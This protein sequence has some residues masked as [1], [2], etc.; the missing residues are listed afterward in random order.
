MHKNQTGD[1]L[2]VV[3]QFLTVLDMV[4]G[5][6]LVCREWYI[7][8]KSE[9]AWEG[10]REGIRRVA[11]GVVEHPLKGVRL[12][13]PGREFT[14]YM[15]EH[16]G[17]EMC[18]EWGDLE[19]EWESQC[20]WVLRD[21]VRLRVADFQVNA[22]LMLEITAQHIETELAYIYSHTKLPLQ[23]H[24]STPWQSLA[25]AL[26]LLIH[27]PSSPDFINPVEACLTTDAYPLC[28]ALIT[29][30]VLQTMCVT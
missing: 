24:I 17:C 4:K 12:A 5:M 23:A 3:A 9:G 20:L 8:S 7:T 30:K 28:D 27:G 2:Q 13:E 10:V 25:E 14:S 16:L 18:K 29:R 22:A 6:R 21:V 11:N 19:L 1:V 15:A 26:I